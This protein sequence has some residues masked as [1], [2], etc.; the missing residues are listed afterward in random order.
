MSEKDIVTVEL[1]Q[2]E[3]QLLLRYGYPFEDAKAQLKAFKGRKGPNRLKIDSRA[4][5]TVAKWFKSFVGHSPRPRRTSS[6]CDRLNRD[7]SPYR[8]IL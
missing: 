5:V 6:P 3:V 2:R 1:S 8:Q 7:F 4:R